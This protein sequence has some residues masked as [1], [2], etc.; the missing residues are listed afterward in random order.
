MAD[1]LAAW[2]EGQ[3][4]AV[5]ERDRSGPRLTYT[6]EALASYAL[7]S[8]LLS[9]SLPLSSRRYTQGVVRPFLDGLLAEGESRTSLARDARV[10]VRDTY[11]LIRAL[12]RDCAGALVIQPGEDPAPSVPTTTTAEPIRAHE[13]EALVRDL[14]SAPLGVGGRV[15]ICLAGV[16]EKLVLTRTPDGSWGRP[17]DGTPSTHILKPEITAFSNTVEN[18][19]FCMRVAAHLKLDVASVETMEIGGRK[20]I[21]RALRPNCWRRP[22]CTAHPPR[23][24]LPGTRPGAGEKVRRRWG[25]VAFANRGPPQRCCDAGLF[26]ATS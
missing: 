26:G 19:A 1:E 6:P 13:F 21:G 4:V 5:I 8:P 7:G 14:T 22:C 9:L 20:L 23:R 25:A 18:E 16:Q 15:R 17:V 3:K 11:G 10:S 24:L 12:G 2:L